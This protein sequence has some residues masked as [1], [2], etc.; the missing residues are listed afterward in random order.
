MRQ[1]LGK[2]EEVIERALIEIR[3]QRIEQ[4]REKA[5]EDIKMVK[6]VVGSHLE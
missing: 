3:K 4:S 6:H 1:S 5:E 2:K